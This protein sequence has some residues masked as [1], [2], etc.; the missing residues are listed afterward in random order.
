MMVPLQGHHRP[1]VSRERLEALSFT[2]RAVRA[3]S[4]SSL[5]KD[6]TSILAGSGTSR[7]SSD[8]VQNVFAVEC[9]SAGDSAVAS[10]D[11]V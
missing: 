5:G 4:S 6:D 7:R 2:R 1:G 10:S 11:S 9:E 8:G 3:L